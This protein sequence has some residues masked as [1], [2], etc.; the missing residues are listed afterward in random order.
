MKRAY[1]SGSDDECTSP[2]KKTGCTITIRNIDNRLGLSATFNDPNT[3]T[4]LELYFTHSKTTLHVHKIILVS[5]SDYFK[6]CLTGQMKEASQSRLEF[7]E[8]SDNPAI[9]IELLKSMY[10]GE[11]NVTE[12]LLVHTLRLASL[13]EMQQ[14]EAKILA[15]MA[16]MK[17]N[18]GFVKE[19]W[20]HLDLNRSAYDSLV[21]KLT[22]FLNAHVIEP[23]M[24]LD[25]NEG[26][27]CNMLTTIHQKHKNVLQIIANWIGHNVEER[28][29][30][31][32]NIVKFANQ[33]EERRGVRSG[34]SSPLLYN[35]D[36][37]IENEREMF[38]GSLQF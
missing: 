9:M 25:F 35:S 38:C 18:I 30:L 20:L 7:K 12:E 19:C 33:V 32:W 3:F 10:T 34:Q 11:I 6:K 23:S 27:I 21:A 24:Y 29:Q 2:K 13:Y 4:D 14:Q 5:Q 1:D 28:S 17:Y 15:R 26:Q 36:D 8:E 37:E 16:T 22:T 31:A